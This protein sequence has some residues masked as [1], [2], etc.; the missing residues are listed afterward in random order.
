MTVPE[1]PRKWA[2]LLAIRSPKRCCCSNGFDARHD[3]GHHGLVAFRRHVAAAMAL[4]ETDHADRQRGPGGDAALHVDA[5]RAACGARAAR[6]A[7]GRARSARSCR[8]RCRTPAC[9]RNCGRSARRSPTPRAW[10]RSPGVTISIDSPV[11]APRP[12]DEL[13][14]IGGDAAGL[15]G[16]QPRAGHRAAA[17]LLGADLERFDG[18]AHGRVGQPARAQ[19]AFAETDDAGERVDDEKAPARGLGDQQPAIIGAE[20]ERAIN[21]RRGRP[22]RRA[23]VSLALGCHAR[24]S[25]GAIERARAATCVGPPP[26]P[27]SPVSLRMALGS[28]EAMAAGRAL[29]LGP[30]TM[31]NLS[32]PEPPSRSSRGRASGALVLCG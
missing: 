20:I 2:R 25:A 24:P 8:R 5:G 26:P 1:V 4:G 32:P 13:V 31:L 11:S 29:P 19:H 7:P 14:A 16:D 22:R 3:V 23:C 15:G 27:Q 21:R 12:L 9:S 28:R 18:A 6:A 17:H 10:P 30:F